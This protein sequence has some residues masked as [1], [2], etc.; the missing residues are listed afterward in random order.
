MEQ[1]RRNCFESREAMTMVYS[2]H[3]RAA[4]AKALDRGGEMSFAADEEKI[5][6]CLGMA[7]IM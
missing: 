2:N 7:V 3:D 6:R 4:P 5:L 1:G